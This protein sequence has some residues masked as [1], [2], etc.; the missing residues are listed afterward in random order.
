MPTPTVI[1]TQKPTEGSTAIETPTA[2]STVTPTQIPT[3]EPALKIAKVS[4]SKTAPQTVGT[5]VK[6][7]AKAMGGN[8]IFQYCFCIKN[9]KGRTVVKTKWNKSSSYNWK[10]DKAGKYK[11]VVMVR[12]NNHKNTTI[13]TSRTLNYQVAQKLS[14]DK[15]TIKKKSKGWYIT[16]K[17]KGGIGTKHYYF[18]AKNSKGK[19]IQL[20]KKYSSKASFYW[21]NVKKGTYKIY[22]K[23][24]D[25]SGSSV[26]CIKIS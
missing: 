11:I 1:P 19:R 8:E 21:K 14:I 2:T 15:I 23:V 26:K 18:Y 12:E 17:S 3:A 5:K 4:C 13:K 7:T 20:S 25:N 24:R 16:A 9:S 22:V 10:P 6:I